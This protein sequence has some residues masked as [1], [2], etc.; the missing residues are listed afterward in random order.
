[1]RPRAGRF[2]AVAIGVC[3]APPTIG[4]F[5]KDAYLFREWLMAELGLSEAIE[6]VR[7]ELRRAMI[8]GAGEEIQFPVGQVTLEFQ[9]GMRK[10]ADGTGKIK[11]WVVEAGAS[12]K[13]EHD[14]VQKVTVILQPPVDA[15]GNPIKVAGGSQVRPG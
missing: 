9:V 10:T 11:V 6:E 12:A 3:L 4:Y 1:M 13:V 5:T 15:S 7:E 14:D 2:P 8:S